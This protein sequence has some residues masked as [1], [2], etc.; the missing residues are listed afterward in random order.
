M[1][2]I[3]GLDILIVDDDP[4]DCLLLQE[5]LQENMVVNQVLIKHD[6]EELLDYLQHCYRLPGLILLDLNMPRKDGREA[7]TD[8]KNNPNL[9]SIPVVILTTSDASEDVQQSYES[10][11]NAFITKPA[12]YSGL[13]TLAHNVRSFWLE[14]AVLPTEYDIR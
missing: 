5:A 3:N 4:D 6:G 2:S 13:V 11:A 1:D 12:S 14:T 7:L 10:G 8:I 9:R